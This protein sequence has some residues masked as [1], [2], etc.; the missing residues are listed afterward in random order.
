M[1][2]YNVQYTLSTTSGSTVVPIQQTTHD[3]VDCCLKSYWHSCTEYTAPD[4]GAYTCPAYD[5]QRVDNNGTEYIIGCSSNT[6]GPCYATAYAPNNFY[7]CIPQCSA[8]GAQC[9]GYVYFMG[10]L[11]G[12]GPGNCCFL[13]YSPQGFARNSGYGGQNANTTVGVLKTEFYGGPY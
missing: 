6:A 1:F 4:P 10:A 12:N 13:S 3:R 9:K 5:L 8:D 11:N 2:T 7:D